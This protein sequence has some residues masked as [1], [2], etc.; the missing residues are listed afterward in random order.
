MEKM[1][2]EA[3]GKGLLVVEYNFYSKR[4]KPEVKEQKEKRN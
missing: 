4:Q 3:E 2:K 1:A